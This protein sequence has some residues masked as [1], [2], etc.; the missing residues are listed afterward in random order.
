MGFYLNVEGSEACDDLEQVVSQKQVP[1]GHNSKNI[2]IQCE[3][4]II[5]VELDLCV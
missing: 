2:K 1:D 3:I 4:A 5:T